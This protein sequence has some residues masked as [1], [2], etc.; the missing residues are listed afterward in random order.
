MDIEWEI[1]GGAT[2]VQ[3][4]DI[5]ATSRETKVRKTNNAI[6]IKDWEDEAKYQANKGQRS[7]HQLV[8]PYFLASYLQAYKTT[9]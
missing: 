6:E 7:I 1:G 2:K 8:Y 4:W 3:K 9:S 5:Q